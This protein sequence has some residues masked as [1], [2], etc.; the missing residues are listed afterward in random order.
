MVT[1]PYDPPII[2]G[3]ANGNIQKYKAT[4]RTLPT[5]L[6]YHLRKGYI[7]P[8]FNNSLVGIGPFCDADCNVLFSKK[9]S[10][11]LTLPDRP[12]SQGGVKYTE[13][14]CGN[15]IYTLRWMTYHPVHPVIKPPR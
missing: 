12:S 13:N 5:H 4:C 7:L 3:T 1:M 10:P 15:Y 2:V 8:A 9:L 11:Y 14:D 6:P